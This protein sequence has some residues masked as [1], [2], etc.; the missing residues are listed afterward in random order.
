MAIKKPPAKKGHKFRLETV[1]LALFLI[2]VVIYGVGEA[3]KGSTGNS[4]QP[5][6]PTAATAANNGSTVTSHPSSGT[7]SAPGTL[8]LTSRDGNFTIS[9]SNGSYPGGQLVITQEPV[10]FSL[11]IS[12]KDCGG[13]WVAR[14]GSS[15]YTITAGCLGKGV[16]HVEIN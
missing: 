4:S 10:G 16:M 14:N 2:V 1:V 7:I 13:S 11:T 8:T 15:S 3:F 12:A 9:L 6:T 5:A